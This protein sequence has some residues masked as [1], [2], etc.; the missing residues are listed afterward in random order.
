MSQIQAHEPRTAPLS[1]EQ[2]RQYQEYGYLVLPQGCSA[3]LIHA[4]NA[5]I[6]SIRSADPIPEWAFPRKRGQEFVSEEERFSVRL[7]NPHKHD[8]FS[9]QMLKLPVV[10]GALAQLMGDEAVGIQS[11]YFYKE[12]GSPGQAAHQDYYYIRNEPDTMIAAWIAMERVDEENGCLWVI[13]GSHKLGLLPHGAVKNVQEHEPWTKE[14]ENIDLSK[15]L[16]VRL[17]KGDILFFHSLLI[18]SSTRNR[19]LDRWRRSYVCH[20]IRHDSVIEREDL[21]V[22]YRLD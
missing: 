1:E 3:D 13:P 21:K 5:H 16:P 7:F 6:H 22:K 19:S 14:T 12:P 17:N 8:G 10:R 2:I 11:M 9:V 15:E 20:Y 4:Y 18:H